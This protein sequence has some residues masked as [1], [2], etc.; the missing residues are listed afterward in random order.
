MLLKQ[1]ILNAIILHR[2][3]KCWLGTNDW[4]FIIKIN[5]PHSF[6]APKLMVQTRNLLGFKLSFIRGD[7][8]LKQ[9]KKN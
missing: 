6:I 7:N 1:K 3:L 4:I 5:I 2:N 9:Q 8:S